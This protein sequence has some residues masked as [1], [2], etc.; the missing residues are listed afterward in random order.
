[1]PT[2][3][4]ADKLEKQLAH[5]ANFAT[6]AKKYSKDPTSAPKGG[7]IVAVEGRLVKPFQNV[8]FSLKTNQISPPVHTVY[9]WHIIQALGPV[10]PAKVTPFK[11][12]EP[13]IQ[14]NLLQQDK[15]TAWN[16]WLAKLKTDFQGKISYQSGYEPATTTTTTGTT[17]T[18]TTG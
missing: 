4:L 15:T 18:T 5:G 13:Q 7:K 8:A 16:N 12:V 3:A 11:Q 6:L 17:P 9:G 1:M 10:K 2:K 14:S